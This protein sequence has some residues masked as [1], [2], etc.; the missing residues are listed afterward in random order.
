M[1]LSP[2][3][4]AHALKCVFELHPAL[5]GTKRKLV[6]PTTEGEDELSDEPNIV[7]RRGSIHNS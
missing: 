1:T 5:E 2:I 6:D 7:R 3:V 4:T